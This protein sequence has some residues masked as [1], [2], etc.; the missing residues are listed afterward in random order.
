MELSFINTFNEDNLKMLKQFLADDSIIYVNQKIERY[1][2]GLIDLIGYISSIFTD[3]ISNIIE[4]EEEGYTNKNLW[5][6]ISSINLC[7]PKAIAR[8]VVNTL[9]KLYNPN[10]LD[11]LMEE[12]DKWIPGKSTSP[13]ENATFQAEK[14]APV[15]YWIEMSKKGWKELAEIALRIISIPP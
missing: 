11:K 1:S 3:I 9:G 8:Y 2:K 7:S 14:F 15:D 4:E 12:F 6:N 5:P 10:D 13:V